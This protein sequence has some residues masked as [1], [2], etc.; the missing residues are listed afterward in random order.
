[1]LDQQV[2][3]IL[4]SMVAFENGIKPQAHYVGKW[5]VWYTSG[6]KWALPGVGF[7]AM[8]SAC[9]PLHEKASFYRYKQ[10]PYGLARTQ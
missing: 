6:M 1:M 4:C 9:D 8:M 10:L 3:D 7:F 5:G 2:L